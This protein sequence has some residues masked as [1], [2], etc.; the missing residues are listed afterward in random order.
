MSHPFGWLQEKYWLKAFVG[1]T[2]ATLIVFAVI[3]A[4][5]KPLQTQASPQGIVSFETAGSVAAAQNILGA[6]SAKARVFAGLSLGIDYLFMV[7]YALAIG[8]GCVLV[9][10]AWH[11]PWE[12]LGV[13]LAW[14]VWVAAGLDAVENVALIRMLTQGTASEPWPRVAA[15]CATIK[16]GLV[17]LGLG[18][19][20]IGGL[21]L[22]FRRQKP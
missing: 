5:D 14:A 3:S 22:L 10:A 11:G 2:I 18:F 7:L 1:L 17:G 16:F 9:G 20:I 19:V 15:A 6:W 4:W 12:R 21:G 13:G 8:L